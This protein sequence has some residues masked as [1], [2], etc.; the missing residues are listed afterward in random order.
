MWT[1]CATASARPV[2]VVPLEVAR[3]LTVG[4]IRSL[5]PAVNPDN[6]ALLVR[7]PRVGRH[8][9]PSARSP[10]SCTWARTSARARS[11]RSFYYRPAPLRVDVE[12]L[13]AGEL[14]V[15]QGGVRLCLDEGRPPLQSHRRIRAGVSADQLHPD[16]RRPRA[17]LAYRRPGTSRR[18]RRRTSSG[19]RSSTRFSASSM[20]CARMGMAARCCWLRPAPR[21]RCPCGRSSTSALTNRSLST[22][23][24]VHQHASRAGRPAGTIREASIA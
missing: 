22:I 21:P 2:P 10:A 17:P 23:R 5:A 12:V 20:A 4:S 16:E 11:G 13:D 14:N 18:A 8:G 3:P 19:R 1:W 9:R 6:A 7:F 24:R 15:Y